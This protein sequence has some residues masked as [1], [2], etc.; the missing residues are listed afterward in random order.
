MQENKLISQVKEY[1]S[2]GIYSPRE[3]FELLYALNRNKHYSTIRRAI[4]VAKT[5][6]YK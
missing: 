3:L 2:Y 5:G 1:M 4:H 6:I